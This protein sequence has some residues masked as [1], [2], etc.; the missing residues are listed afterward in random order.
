M[1]KPSAFEVALDGLRRYIVAG[2]LSPG[3]PLPP[4]AELA[5]EL[6]VSQATLRE[7]LRAWEAAGILTIR[8]GVGAFVQRYDWAPVLRNLSVSA[9]FEPQQGAL[10]RQLRE[11][12]EIGALPG[13]IERLTT[14]DLDALAALAEE[15]STGEDGLAAEFRLHLRLV[16]ALGNPLV[17]ELLRLAWLTEQQS[18]SEERAPRSR[19]Y[20]LH[21]EL[22]QA[23]QARD[24]GAAQAALRRY[25]SQLATD[26]PL[27]A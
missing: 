3:D 1:E 13:A 2:Q 27:D 21:V 7:A 11:A 6:G 9:L 10:L 24:L 12:L 18:A 23:L 15:I 14:G 20:A 19:R 26:E 25:F 22:V 17:E 4:V 16:Q 8:H 5:Q